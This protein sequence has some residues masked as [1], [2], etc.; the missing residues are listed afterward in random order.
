MAEQTKKTETTAAEAKTTKAKVKKQQ[1]P[2]NLVTK[3]RES[4]AGVIELGNKGV[5]QVQATG[6]KAVAWLREDSVKAVKDQAAKGREVAVA[7][8]KKVDD[9]VERTVTTVEERLE[10]VNA[11]LPA[12]AQ[13]LVKRGQTQAREARAKVR[14][15]ISA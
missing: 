6:E 14:E 5:A 9:A 11:K 8:V 3:A 1:K 12:K 4:L 2:Q 7:Q 13:E 15:R 10:P